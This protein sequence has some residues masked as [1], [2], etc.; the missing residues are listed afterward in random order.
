MDAAYARN[1]EDAANASD[2]DSVMDKSGVASSEDEMTRDMD[3]NAD[4][5]FDAGMTQ[6][7]WGW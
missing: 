7:Y 1:H 3:Y 6:H 4:F 2:D 5:D